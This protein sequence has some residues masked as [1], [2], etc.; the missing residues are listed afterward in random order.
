MARTLTSLMGLF[1]LTFV[2]IGCQQPSDG[3]HQNFGSS[4]PVEGSDSGYDLIQSNMPEMDSPQATEAKRTEA[5]GVVG[6]ID[7]SARS[8]CCNV[9]TLVRV[10]ATHDCCRTVHCS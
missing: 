2:T 3:S 6:V 9:Q 4:Q 7:Q 10:A 8:G 5:K 1:L